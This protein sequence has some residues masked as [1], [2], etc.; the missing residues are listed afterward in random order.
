MDFSKPKLRSEHAVLEQEIQQL[1]QEVR[2]HQQTSGKEA[3]NQTVISTVIQKRSAALAPSQPLPQSSSESAVLP[4]YLNQES[5][6]TK[7]KIEELIDLAFHKGINT[8]LKEA[9]KYGPFFIDAYH[10]ALTAKLYE[11][12]KTRKLL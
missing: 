12:L 7:L 10:D 8:G 4:A 9:K 5:A 2:E 3:A 11:E 1:I 6:E